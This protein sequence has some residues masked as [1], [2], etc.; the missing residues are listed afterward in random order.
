MGRDMTTLRASMAAVAMLLAIPM[1]GARAQ[2]SLP[3][4][5]V[6]TQSGPVRGN[7]PDAN[8]IT[9]FKGIPYAAPPVGP[10]RWRPPQP[11]AFYAGI[12]EAASY[13]SPCWA[14]PY[15]PIDPAAPPSEDC[16]TLNIWAQAP[17]FGRYKPV[18]VR[19]HGGG[20]VFGSSR[21]PDIDGSLL[22]TKDVVV[23]NFN[24]RLNAFGFLALPGLDQ[25]SGS[26]GAFGLQDQIA[27][28]RWV[29]RNIA[30]FGG[31]P[32]NVTVFGESAGAHAIGILMASPEARGLFDKAIIESGAWWD[33]EHG[34]MSTHAQALQEGQALAAKLNVGDVA[35]LRAL[36][37]ATIN[38]AASWNPTTDPGLTAF[39]PSIDGQVTREPPGAVFARGAEALIPLLGG[40]NANEDLPIFRPRGLPSTT[41]QVFQAAAQLQFGVDRLAQ[42]NALYPSTDAAQAT[43][44]ANRLSGELVIS[45]QTWEALGDQSRF[46][47]V[48]TYAYQ[49]SYTSAYLPVAAHATEPTFVFGTLVPQRGNGGALPTAADRAI[50][51]LFMN[52]WTNFAKQG[53]PNGNG[54]PYW[55]TYAGAGSNV[56]QINKAPAAGPET[57]TADFQFIQSYRKDGVLPAFWRTI[58]LH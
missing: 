9:S 17:Q 54:L 32:F 1:D 38:N 45:E 25:E 34:T 14:T 6:P 11:P 43:A 20:F 31:N 56:M 2:S 47:R 52:Y 42:F 40:W 41:P 48:P 3:N 8:G 37:A 35:S 50:S 4:Y 19:I 36:P 7:P 12:R 58:N 10:L 44:S 57:G 16:L 24:Y 33:S 23:V 22:A 28:L 18:M 39:T 13:G 30:A 27:A 53:N 29:R 26:S 46:R 15:F 51:S 21:T 55:P 5:P 49:F